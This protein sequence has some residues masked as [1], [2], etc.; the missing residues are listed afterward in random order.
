MTNRTTDS[1]ISCSEH[2]LTRRA[3]FWGWLGFGACFVPDFHDISDDDSEFAPGCMDIETIAVLDW[4]D[5]IRALVSGKIM[6]NTS[7][8]MDLPII[9]SL[10]RSRV[11]VLPPYYPPRG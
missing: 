10:A 1:L 8:K 4:G 7:V 3:R 5:R 9:R 6:V 2:R 11:S